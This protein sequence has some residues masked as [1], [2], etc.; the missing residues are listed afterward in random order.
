MANPLP[1]LGVK[2]TPA[3]QTKFWIA[4]VPENPAAME[5][6]DWLKIPLMDEVEFTPEDSTDTLQAF[7]EMY[8]YVVRTGMGGT[9]NFT[10]AGAAG[11]GSVKLLHEKTYSTDSDTVFAYRIQFP[12]DTWRF[13]Y[14]TATR[15]LP[16]TDARGIFKY[17]LNGHLTGPQ[18][19]LDTYTIPSP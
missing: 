12:D 3:S 1:D 6:E 16:L 17:R 19:F 7:E 15:P 14:F 2:P 18:A 11:D 4:E 10:T 8:D 9:L 13:G 5:E